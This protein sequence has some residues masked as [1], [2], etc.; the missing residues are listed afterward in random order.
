MFGRKNQSSY[1]A[2]QHRKSPHS[3]GG[4]PPYRKKV[5]FESL[6]QRLLLAADPTALLLGSSPAELADVH[7]SSPE[8][9]A[10]LSPGAAAGVAIAPPSYL[11]PARARQDRQ[12]IVLDVDGAVDITYDGPVHLDGIDVPAFQAPQHLTGQE[13]EILE[14][15][16]GTLEASFRD[17]GI[18]FVIGS[19]SSEEE[20]SIIYLGGDGSPFSAY[21]AIWALAEQVDH[22]NLDRSD[23]AFVFTDAIE[24]DDTSAVMAGRAL[25]GYVVHEIG[26]LLGHEHMHT[27]QTGDAGDLLAAVAFKPYTHVEIA[28]DVRSD[29][30]D[31]G[32]LTIL[33]RSYSVH[34]R[35]VEALRD[36]ESFYYAGTVGPDGF[37]DLVMG[38]SVIHPIDTGIWLS[39]VLD[40]A[41]AAQMDGSPYGEEEQ[42]QILAWSYGYLTHAAGDIWAHTLV[43][44]FSGGPFPGP[45]EFVD[46]AGRKIKTAELSNA[47]RHLMVEEYIAD[48]T[49]GFDGDPERS[50]LRA[51]D[52][53]LLDVTDDTTPEIV[54]DAP[55]DFIYQTFL[56][57]L[58]PNKG[59]NRDQAVPLPEWWPKDAAGAASGGMVVDLLLELR[60]KLEEK[61]VEL[62]SGQP[63]DDRIVLG[64][65]IDS[66]LDGQAPNQQALDGLL[67]IYLKNWIADIDEGLRHW[68]EWSLALTKALF[69]PQSRRDLQNEVGADKG[70]EHS[71]RRIDAENAIGAIGVFLEELEDPDGDGR[72][73]DS[74]VNQYFL[75]MLGFPDQ[76]G[77][78]RS[79]LDQFSDEIREAI[80]TPLRLILNP[81][82]STIADAKQAV[83][84]FV[85]GQILERFGVDAQTFEFLKRM[86][87]K[88]DLE[89]VTIGGVTI[90]LF[91]D[92]D[93][94]LLDVYLGLTPDDHE[95]RPQG[96]ENIPGVVY[97]TDVLGALKDDAV[98]DK[99]DFAA[100]ANSV[101]LAAMLLL[102]ETELPTGADTSDGQLS[103]LFQD[104]IQQPYDFGKLL[105]NGEHGGNILTA[106]LPKVDAVE[107]V[108]RESKDGQTL[109]RES[110]DSPWLVSIDAGAPWVQTP[111]STPEETSDSSPESEAYFHG[112]GN[113][114]LWESSLLRDAFR[115]LFEDWHGERFPDQIQLSVGNPAQEISHLD[116]TSADPNT[117]AS[118]ADVSGAL[119][120]SLATPWEIAPAP[121]GLEIP[122]TPKLKAVILDGLDQLVRL[123]GGLDG[124][125]GLS[126]PLPVFGKSMSQ[127]LASAGAEA[128]GF[129]AE[130]LRTKL[131]QPVQAY[132][133]T[134][135]PTVSGLL[136]VLEQQF[137]SV[138]EGDGMDGAMVFALDLATSFR[139]A[140]APLDLASVGTSLGLPIGPDGS[141][142]VEV[143]GTLEATPTERNP[144]GFAFGIDLTADVPFADRFFIQIDTLRLG[145]KVHA[146]DLDFTLDL[147]FLEAGVRDGT[148]TLDVQV[149]AMFQD[150]NGDG[151]LTFGELSSTALDDLI[152]IVGSGQGTDLIAVLP[153][154]A[155]LGNFEIPGAGQQVRLHI[156][157][158]NVLDGGVDTVELRDGN[159][160]PLTALLQQIR[161]LSQVTPDNFVGLLRQLGA[162]LGLFSDS[163]LLNTSLPFTNGV[164]VGDLLDVLTS[165]EA[166]VDA[167]LKEDGT[168]DFSTVQDA[169]R[170]LLGSDADEATLDETLLTIP[171]RFGGDS[172][173][174]D[175]PLSFDVALGSLADIR[176][177]APDGA[178]ADRNTLHV[179]SSAS[180]QLVLG[181]DLR[182]LGADFSLVGRRL[183]DL[184][185]DGGFALRLVGEPGGR[186][187]RTDGVGDLGFSLRDGTVYEVNLDGLTRLDE[188]VA[189]IASQTNNKVVVL[190]NA[191][192]G[193][194]LVDLSAAGTE[195]RTFRV[196]QLGGSTVLLGMGWG[197]PEDDGAGGLLLIA[198]DEDGD[199][200]I[201]GRPLHGDSILK[202]VFIRDASLEGSIALSIPDVDAQ[203]RF[204]PVGIEV[205]DGTGALTAHL[206]LSLQD[207]DL[208]PSTIGRIY[209]DELAMALSDPAKLSL[210]VASPRFQGQASLALPAEARIFGQ[211]LGTELVTV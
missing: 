21:G 98:L 175:V 178:D 69:D 160:Q 174:L 18:Q 207:P 141:V 153:L 205:A 202:H 150:P 168:P 43:N 32:M 118:L 127:L 35:I 107:V 19:D 201:E 100:Y 93:R 38:Q 70:D 7:T 152:E 112:T 119:E 89:S 28:K 113:F 52:G 39:R 157:D 31:D 154:T 13:A 144:T 182:P 148:I 156:E 78:I 138:I 97:H 126:R 131:Q 30:L 149:D 206:A 65:V 101:T 170:L 197:D 190:E 143:D 37:P 194:D 90:P 189:A 145:A 116:A 79:A 80:L 132:L 49:P 75:P 114:P 109:V 1:A 73:D 86:N 46:I 94:N 115:T 208:R 88:M 20:Q 169:L 167:L 193:V 11:D 111:R 2:T 122:I 200:R 9:S 139:A 68:S 203:A 91:K 48:A 41:W 104:L 176:L 196:D 56:A 66:L 159:N 171:I 211:P 77:F 123:A 166:R 42:L 51:E 67:S 147:G 16:L 87:A 173:T 60:G 8:I 84:D 192:K 33:D 136:D 95:D 146:S 163:D 36:Y 55:H 179:T 172:A 108:Y 191:A 74:F 3:N 124:D 128:G 47:L 177:A 22:G 23:I 133:E 184:N 110:N 106:T 121:A 25:A 24:Y 5:L 198:A 96:I 130:Q 151:R 82:R 59:P 50:E 186:R 81:L 61:R 210:L 117:D 105:L 14:S 62:G 140:D 45:S 120:I 103:Q 129:V 17:T 53:T 92:E 183:E 125:P 181:I 199:G 161:N 187:I 26:H 142:T 40:M 99:Q 4:V 10:D 76:I 158:E 29:V 135:E 83:G 15:L 64:Q 185:G 102:H 57:P 71:A 204:G 6:E 85:E 34:P 137:G 63:A 155:R 164:R 12:L 162:T 44:E 180:G 209:L 165:L 58:V 134:Q 72:I 54:F 188:V 27:V 195:D